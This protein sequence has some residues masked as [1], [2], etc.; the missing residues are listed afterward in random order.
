MLEIVYEPQEVWS[1]FVSNISTRDSEHLI[2]FDD[3]GCEVFVMPKVCDDYLEKEILPYITIY[4]PTGDIIE[5][6]CISQ[7]DCETTVSEIYRDLQDGTGKYA[8]K[9]DEEEHEEDLLEIIDIRESELFEACEDFL[10]VVVDNICDRD[11]YCTPDKIEELLNKFLVFIDKEG[12]PVYRPTMLT[13]EDGT[14]IYSEYP[15][16][17]MKEK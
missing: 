15:Y 3:I 13:A 5:E 2:A 1:V 6:F 8:C 4:Y 14:M 9:Y 11:A 12:I 10:W 17:K 16:E 7:K